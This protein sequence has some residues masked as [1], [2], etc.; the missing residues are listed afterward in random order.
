MLHDRIDRTR[1]F[2]IKRRFLNMFFSW[3][4]PAPMTSVDVLV[5]DGSALVLKANQTLGPRSCWRW[6]W[7][8]L[9]SLLIEAGRNPNWHRNWWCFCAGKLKSIVVIRIFNASW[10]HW[11]WMEARAF[12]LKW[13]RTLTEHILMAALSAIK[14][15][16]RSWKGNFGGQRFFPAPGSCETFQPRKYR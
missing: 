2:G 12:L 9:L 7:I 10:T 13:L 15:N 1:T 14:S 8:I 5:V 6:N 11:W 4:E 16:A 3:A